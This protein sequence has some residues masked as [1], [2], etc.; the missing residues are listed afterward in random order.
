MVRNISEPSYPKRKLEENWTFK[1]AS[2]HDDFLPVAQFPTVVHL[3]LLY[4][5]KIP[6]PTID[7]NREACRWVGE[8]KWLYRTTFSHAKSRSR[9]HVDLVFEG[10]DT[11]ATVTLSGKEILQAAC[12]LSIESQFQTHFSMVTM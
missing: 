6:D 11:F 9:S 10:L 5:G 8:T 2:R 12:L 7:L 3:D 4:H 1:E